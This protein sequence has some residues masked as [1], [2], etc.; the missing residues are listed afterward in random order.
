MQKSFIVILLLVIFMS[1]C[2]GLNS[3]K[4]FKEQQ[5]SENYAI[6]GG[7]QS[8]SPEMIDGDLNTI[9]KASFPVREGTG[10]PSRNAEV[11]ITLPEKKTIN[12]IVIHSDDLPDFKVLAYAGTVGG[13]DDW[14]LINE[15]TNNKQKEIVIKTS[16]QT[17]KILIRAKGKLPLES[18]KSVRV[19]GGVMR[20]RTL[21]EP[22][23]REIEL[24][25]FK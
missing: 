22:E 4:L 19:L 20:T 24:Y 12:K 3:Q 14:K 9:G 13:I 23:I 17:D 15:F 16:I 21:L 10:E 2:A 8:T 1:S 7:V 18:T 5:W 25:G 11:I 6:A